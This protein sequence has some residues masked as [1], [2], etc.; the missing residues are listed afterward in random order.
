MRWTLVSLLPALL[1][2]CVATQEEPPSRQA[3]AYV[4][5]LGKKLP[6]GTSL[7]AAIAQVEADGFKCREAGPWPMPMGHDIVCGRATQPAWGVR[8]QAG[9]D[10]K[11]IAVGSFERP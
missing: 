1:A 3:A 2:G 10:G 6:S 7:A 9:N 4:A 5:Q 11:L 8:L